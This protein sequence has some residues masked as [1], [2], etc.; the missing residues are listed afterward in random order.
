[1]LPLRVPDLVLPPASL[2]LLTS[3]LGAS[4]NWLVLHFVTSALSPRS[5]V[6]APLSY[7]EDGIGESKS[8][9]GKK[10]VVKVVLVSFLRDW[11]FWRTEA[12]RLVGA[13]MCRQ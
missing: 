10:E 4:S 6:F 5:T 2:L 1:M 9:I 12:R 11:E 3:V 13:S 7:Q 8:V